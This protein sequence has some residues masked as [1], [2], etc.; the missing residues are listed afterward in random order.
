MFNANNG[1]RGGQGG[2][3][4]ARTL[5]DALDPAI[6][7][8][9]IEEARRRDTPQSPTYDDWDFQDTPSTSRGPF[10]TSTSRG[11]FHMEEQSAE[12]RYRVYSF[13]SIS[14]I[15][16]E[17]AGSLEASHATQSDNVSTSANAQ[18]PSTSD[19]LPTEN[20]QLRST[21]GNAS[22]SDSQSTDALPSSTHESD[23]PAARDS[24][25]CREDG[26]LTLHENQRMSRRLP[27]LI[28]RHASG[29]QPWVTKLVIEQ[30]CIVISLDSNE[31]ITISCDCVNLGKLMNECQAAPAITLESKA[32][33]KQIFFINTETLRRFFYYSA[34][35]YIIGQFA[36]ESLERF[37]PCLRAQQ[38]N[39]H[40][41]IISHAGRLGSITRAGIPA[42][43][44][45]FYFDTRGTDNT[46]LVDNLY[47]VYKDVYED[48]HHATPFL[49]N[50]QLIVN[51]FCALGDALDAQIERILQ[52]LKCDVQ[53]TAAVLFSIPGDDDIYVELT[54]KRFIYSHY[55]RIEA[56]DGT[57]YMVDYWKK[58]EDGKTL[59]FGFKS[60]RSATNEYITIDPQ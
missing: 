54:N 26:P 14:S 60:S 23:I 29:T 40:R 21:S 47:R 7:N 42:A 16:I 27:F 9:I 1:S 32:F 8:L 50:F 41:W 10:Q 25:Y 24:V 46:T 57:N 31:T 12:P 59:V 19:N 39:V 53:A 18:H 20:V 13:D 56:L 22:T 43:M 51:D 49:V 48:V 6:R 37:I 30:C 35:V 2:E 55:G 44:E 28:E 34:S 4:Y 3:D 52:M 5:F 33:K 15:N 58:K 45:N 38:I 17:P 11:N 36:V